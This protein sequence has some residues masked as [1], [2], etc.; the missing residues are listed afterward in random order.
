VLISRDP[1]V[2][3]MAAALARS[4]AFCL[5]ATAGRHDSLVGVLRDAGVIGAVT[6]CVT[7]TALLHIWGVT[8]R[9]GVCDGDDIVLACA[10]LWTID[11]A[12]GV[13]GFGQAMADVGWVA[14]EQGGGLRFPKLLSHI[15]SPEEREREMAKNRKRRQRERERDTRRDPSRDSHSDVTPRLENRREENKK[16]PKPPSEAVNILPSSLDTEA[17]RAAWAQ[18]QQHRR[19][20]RQPLTPTAVK[21]QLK[22]LEGWGHD[23]A[24]AAIAHSVAQGYT[25]L[26]EGGGDGR[27]GPGGGVGRA[28]RVEPPPGKYDGVG[29]RVRSDEVEQPAP[30]SLFPDEAAGGRADPHGPAGNAAGPGQ[31]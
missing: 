16:P 17:F 23:R 3:A 31:G 13:P 28:G 30:P 15:T 19:E 11:R 12:S 29:I 25:G 5:W 4:P 9:D 10:D 22:K 8:R 6:E 2:I 24:V 14:A 20:K 26:F 7:V 18:W 21:Q 27:A 1:K